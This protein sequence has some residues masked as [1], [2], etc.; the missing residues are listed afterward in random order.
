MAK[1]STFSTNTPFIFDMQ[2]INGALFFK[3]TCL[4]IS[5]L[6]LSSALTVK[7]PLTTIYA[8]LNSH[9]SYL[10]IDILNL[11]CLFVLYVSPD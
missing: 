3:I 2:E 1:S 5:S 10:K 8:L 11:I 7:I 9:K 4:F 6:S